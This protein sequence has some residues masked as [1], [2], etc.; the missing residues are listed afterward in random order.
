MSLQH[1]VKSPYAKRGDGDILVS[2][3]TLTR[4][5][6]RQLTGVPT[7]VRLIYLPMLRSWWQSEYNLTPQINTGVQHGNA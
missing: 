6:Y 2:P 7:G 4:S 5:G 3:T 1:G